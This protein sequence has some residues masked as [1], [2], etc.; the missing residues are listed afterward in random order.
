MWQT[1]DL[2]DAEAEEVLL[3]DDAISVKAQ[4]PERQSD[5]GEATEAQDVAS[6][7]RILTDVVVFQTAPGQ[8][9][10]VSAPIDTDGVPTLSLAQ[11]VQSRVQRAYGDHSS[12]L[13]VVVISDGASSIRKR[14]KQAFGESVVV[15]LDWYHLSKKLRELMS[16]IARSK[17]EKQAHL[18][19]LLA[20]LWRGQTQAAIDYI[21]HQVVA[22]NHEKWQELL[23]YLDKHQ[24]EIG[25]YER[26]QQAGKPIGS[27]RVEK[28]VDQVIGHRQKHKGTSWRP[29][30]SRALG[31]LK[32][33]ELNGQWQ[34]FW[35]SQQ[36]G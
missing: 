6:T 14:W 12:A 32:V 26:R 3:F 15:I 31:L 19:V 1:I 13:P 4:K 18:K 9:E 28:A 27:G 29:Q 16:M 8:Y 24:H 10:Y 5:T 7:S 30:G 33:L 21:R 23:A 20:Q 35:F 36:L 2:Y 25:H 22:R 34:Q 11:V 17:P